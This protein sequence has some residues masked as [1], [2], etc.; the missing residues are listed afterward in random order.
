MKKIFAVFIVIFTLILM[1]AIPV[2]GDAFSVSIN[3]S[4][5]DFTYA[6]IVNNDTVYME[7]K[8][9]LGLGWKCCGMGCR[10]RCLCGFP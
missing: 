4:A 6:P 7:V 2:C 8:E 3:G 1:G 5:A 9:L 10:Q